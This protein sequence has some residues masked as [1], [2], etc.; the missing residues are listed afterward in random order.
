LARR[1]ANNRAAA[2]LHALALLKKLREADTSAQRVE[3]L[4]ALYAHL[5]QVANAAYNSSLFSI[6]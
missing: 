1:I 5:M 4:K 3:Q 2:E 6:F